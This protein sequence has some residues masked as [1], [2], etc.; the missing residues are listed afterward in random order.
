TVTVTATGNVAP[1][2]TQQPVSQTA[3]PN[4]TVLLTMAASGSPAPSIVWYRNGQ[5]FGA[6]WT[7]PALTMYGVSSNDNGTYVA[8]ATNL[9]GTATTNPVTVSVIP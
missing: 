3:V 8:V 6:G 5:T 1:A 2:I 7:G 4:S 9:A